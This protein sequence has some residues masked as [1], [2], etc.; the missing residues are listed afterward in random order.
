MKTGFWLRG[1][2][3][4]LAGA[5]VYK[6]GNGDTVMREVVTPSNPKTQAQMV[7]R[8]IMHTVM[9]AYSKM[10][11]I[12]DHSFEGT[13]KGRDTMSLFMKENVQKCRAAVAEMQ[14]Q[15]VAFINMYNFSL[16]GTKNFAANQY[17]VAM[18]SLPRVDT[19]WVEDSTI[20]YPTAQGITTNT[21]ESVI[22]SLGLKRGD[23]LTFC[24][25]TEGANNVTEFHFA[26]VIL[27]PTTSDFQPAPLSSPLVDAQGAIT[28]PS[29]RNEGTANF[30]FTVTAAGLRYQYED[31][32]S[33]ADDAIAAYVIVSRK[34]GDTWQRSTTFMTYPGSLPNS[35]SL[36]E[37][38]EAAE[39]SQ[40]SIYTGADAY[41]NNAGTGG[42]AG[43]AEDSNSGNSGNAQSNSFAIGSASVNNEAITVGTPKVQTLGEGE[44]EMSL[45]IRV[46][47]SDKGSATAV[48]V[49]KNGTQVGTDHELSG[50]AANFSIN[51]ATVGTYTLKVKKSDNTVSAPGYS[52]TVQAYSSGGGYDPNYG[53]IGDGN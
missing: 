18:G 30:K 8:I 9:T 36:G 34:M 12:C 19:Q 32:H 39:G 33:V 20:L 42:G 53:D 46:T 48:I 2:K 5:T 45:D 3:G 6:D 38:L 28:F 1:G 31:M 27:D 24:I 35:A 52:I 13:K 17:L 29:V 7:Q 21:Y 40:S 51:A 23:Q 22:Q 43:S 10:K 37:C 41:L 50:N 11:E 16:L 4:Q 44:D 14:A 26:R 15:G 49:E 25:V 47:F